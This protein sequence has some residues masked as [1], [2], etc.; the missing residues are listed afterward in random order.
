LVDIPEETLDLRA[1]LTDA[2]RRRPTWAWARYH[3]ER[4]A[5]RSQRPLTL[6]EVVP[7]GLAHSD[8]TLVQVGANDGKRGDPVEPFIEA[9]GWAGLLV[10]PL[11]EPFA[12]LGERY[13][14]N[15][16]VALANVAVGEADGELTLYL[17]PGSRSTTASALPDRNVLSRESDLEPVTVE[18]LTFGTLFE[19]YGTTRVDVLQIDTEGF[20]YRILRSF[21]FESHHP[22]IVNFEY[23]CLPVGERL[24]ACDLLRANGYAF[25][26]GRRDL[27]AVD[28]SRFGD[29]LGITDTEPVR[30]SMTRVARDSYRRAVARARQLPAAKRLARAARRRLHR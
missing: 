13:A 14:G 25:S 19:R 23:Y 18:C 7:L 8:V 10:E 29:A 16:R 9:Y 12:L 20:D 1:V 11:P 26:F 27:L 4:S 5:F 24:A 28:R 22:L 6:D 2:V 21:D 30:P 17:K 15:D 3:L